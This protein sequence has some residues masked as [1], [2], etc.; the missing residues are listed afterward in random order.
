MNEEGHIVR[1]DLQDDLGASHLAVSIS[2][3]GVEEAGIVRAQLTAG[4]FISH[5][6]SRIARRHPNTLLRCQDI[7]LLRF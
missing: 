4:R 2:E 5:H 1:A 7:K 6:L 3:A